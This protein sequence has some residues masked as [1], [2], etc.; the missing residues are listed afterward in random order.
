LTAL[1]SW[2]LACIAFVFQALIS[3]VIILAKLGCSKDKRGSKAE[4]EEIKMNN[5]LQEKRDV[6]LEWILFSWGF[7]SAFIFNV[8]YWTKERS[9]M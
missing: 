4:A 8:Y 5:Y 7:C 3:Y 6:L 2:C 1:E 9:L